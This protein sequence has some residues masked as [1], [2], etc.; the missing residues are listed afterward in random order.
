MNASLR[1][2]KPME[3]VPCSSMETNV[4][5]DDVTDAAEIDVEADGFVDQKTNNEIEQSDKADTRKALMTLP[6]KQ[7][8]RKAKGLKL[9]AEGSKG[10]IVERII[11]KMYADWTRH[12]EP[13]HEHEA[14]VQGVVP[15][16]E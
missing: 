8:K 10:D 4:G 2:P 14:S 13:D 11:T 9:S 1:T 12:N 3:L 7:L 5:A 6:E 16:D 15:K